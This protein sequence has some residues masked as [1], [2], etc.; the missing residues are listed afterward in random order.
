[1]QVQEDSAAPEHVEH[2]MHI[3]QIVIRGGFRIR[4][5]GAFDQ[6]T[7]NYIFVWPRG[8]TDSCHTRSAL[9]FF[10]VVK[11]SHIFSDALIN[12]SSVRLLSGDSLP[13][14]SIHLHQGELLT[15]QLEASHRKHY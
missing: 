4:T 8:V 1:M 6:I 5:D 7:C 2:A 9:A 12:L 14:Q 10:V 11:R 15:L 13:R 3:R